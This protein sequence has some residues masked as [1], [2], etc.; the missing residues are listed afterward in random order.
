M[1]LKEGGRAKV[2]KLQNELKTQ[3]AKHE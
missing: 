3:A 2:E 1:E